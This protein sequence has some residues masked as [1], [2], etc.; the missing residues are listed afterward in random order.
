MGEV[1]LASTTGL[2]GAERP[3]V[4]KVI[5]REHAKDPSFLARFLDEARVQAQLQHP[6]VA[7]VL[8]AAMDDVTGEPYVVV[9]HVEGRSLGDV[10]ARAVQMGV[11]V[12]WP[13]AAAIAVMIAEALA[14]VHERQDATGRALAIVHRDLSPQNVMMSYA[15]DI[16]LIDFGTA[17]GQNRRCHT[18]AG[19]VF[20]KPGYVAPEVANGNVGDARVDLYAL[21]V[22]LW[23]LCAGRRF[24]QGEASD[25]LAA[26]ARNE[27]NLPP[28]A[29]EVDMPVELDRII[30]KLTSFDRDDRYLAARMAACDLAKV[31]SAAPAMPSGERG[32]RAR[33]ALLMQR[34]FPA[35]PA[36]SRR[37]FGRLAVAAR[38][39]RGAGAGPAQAAPVVAAQPEAGAHKDLLP[40]TRYQLGREIGRGASSVVY[41]AHHVDLGRRVAIKVLAAEPSR[42]TE[43]AERFR[44]EARA[45][46][47][48][49][50]PSLVKLHDVGVSADGRL[51]GVMELLEGET[52]EAFMAREKGVDWR[53]ALTLVQKSLR[54]LVAAHEAGIVHRDIKPANLFLTRAGE[55]KLLDFG[56][57]IGADEIAEREQGD[58]AA[59]GSKLAGLTLFGTPEYMAPEQAASGRVDA[60]AD[61]YALGCV[62]YE[63]LT[64]RLPFA[65]P[66]SVAILD[67]KIKGSPERPRDRAPTRGIP[68]AIDELTMRAIARHPS[69]RFQTAVEMLAAVDVAL[70]EPSKRRAGRRAL[71]F[72]A[73]AA[74]MAIAAGLL[75]APAGAGR[76]ILADVRAPWMPAWIVGSPQAEKAAVA[77][78]LADVASDPPASA[79]SLLA[80]ADEQDAPNAAIDHAQDPDQDS[81]ESDELLDDVTGSDLAAQAQDF[82]PAA[83]QDP[84]GAIPAS[85]GRARSKGTPIA[86]AGHDRG[87]ASEKI[88]SSGQDRRP[89]A[90][91]DRPAQATV[92]AAP[93]APEAVAAPE[94]AITASIV[95]EAPLSP[96]AEQD[97][98]DEATPPAAPVDD[99]TS[100]PAA[101]SAPPASAPAVDP[102]PKG[103][104]AAPGSSDSAARPA[105]TAEEKLPAP[106]KKS[107]DAKARKKRKS[108]LAKAK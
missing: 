19:V 31:L 23:E 106:K 42:S 99:A 10:R 65:R 69:V 21:G 67:A 68:V 85:R 39:H 6:G 44:R 25:H 7:Q 108:R 104:R 26:V 98:S 38:A 27:K 76:S 50:H 34:L 79:A 14:H 58:A 71:G 63:M 12:D 80:P 60:R 75:A 100:S 22:M 52:L 95:L 33:A 87:P 61:L 36:R 94:I 2:E 54:A 103:A 35:E 30:A 56:L 24:L 101:A 59:E 3:V 45:L 28:I 51:F 13:S 97:D 96:L 37:E 84:P 48:L 81:L 8:D 43:L 29:E 11:R 82:A 72:V 62:L 88:A 4:V 78:I 32:I 64:G 89:A 57:A 49:S 16:K 15:G 107:G 70:A 17:R 1:H 53:E 40:G 90:E 9:E 92:P 20:A 93:R 105:A 73:L 55:V 66:S 74:S 41:E 83:D 46:S 5:R 102:A 47:R 18:V 77:P 86:G 91:P